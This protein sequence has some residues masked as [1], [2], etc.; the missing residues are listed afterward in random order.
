[1]AEK[2]ERVLNYVPHRR[3]ISEKLK[4]WYADNQRDL[5]WRRTKNPYKIWISEVILQQTRVEQGM[6]YYIRFITRFPT[7]RSLAEADEES[8]L[9]AWEGLGYYS[10]ARNLHA[11]A[12]QIMAQFEEIF[13]NNYTDLL[14]LRGVGQYTAAAIASYS[15]RITSTQASRKA[16]SSP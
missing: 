8:V 4:I 9:K 16:S 6:D 2:R 1:M 3:L 12:K 14:T 5:P 11:A 7:V 10:R 13:P 15:G